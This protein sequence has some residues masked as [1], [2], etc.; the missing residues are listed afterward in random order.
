MKI[1]RQLVGGQVDTTVD[2]KGK[3]S[4]PEARS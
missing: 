4:R 1:G 2:K 3:V